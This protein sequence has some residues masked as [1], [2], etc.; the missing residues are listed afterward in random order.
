VEHITHS[1]QEE[2]VSTSI[3]LKEIERRAYLSYYG[4]GLLDIFVGVVILS[5]PF[6]IITDT[7]WMS[8]IMI[9]VLLPLWAVGKRY[10]TVPRMG[11]V[12]FGS[13]RTGSLI[14]MYAA[15]VVGL[16]IT[17]LAGLGVFLA[18]KDTMPPWLDVGLGWLAENSLLALGFVALAILSFGA[19]MSG[20]NRLY[21]YGLLGLITLATG[22]FLDGSG[23]LFTALWGGLVILCGLFM[24]ARFIRQYPV[25]AEEVHNEIA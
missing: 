19:A 20:I 4:D 3:D 10:I 13:A 8:G 25:A 9:A 22:H 18:A 7:L 11:V 1:Q 16:L 14:R 15:V 17:F 23:A 6:H 2:D 5:I 24:L 12:K 21:G